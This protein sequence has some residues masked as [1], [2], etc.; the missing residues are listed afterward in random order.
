MLWT[1]YNTDTAR[2][3]KITQCSISCAILMSINR[4]LDN[5]ES[6][7][8][9]QKKKEIKIQT[10]QNVLGFSSDAWQ[11]T[12]CWDFQIVSTRGRLPVLVE[13]GYGLGA[14]RAA[15]VTYRATPMEWMASDFNISVTSVVTVNA[16]HLTLQPQTHWS[17]YCHSRLTTST[18][19]PLES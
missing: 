3:H 12:R 6:K 16:W 7:R 15:V 19:W 18:P 13:C 17:H 11:G 2:H 9:Q 10:G 8:H 14:A 1:S 5:L 4:G